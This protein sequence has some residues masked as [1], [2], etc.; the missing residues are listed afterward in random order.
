MPR[1]II[2]AVDIIEQRRHT[3]RVGHAADFDLRMLQGERRQ[4]F[5]QQV[6]PH[7]IGHAQAQRPAQLLLPLAEG[8]RG[9]FQRRQ[10]RLSAFMQQLAVRRQPHRT[11]ATFEQSLLELT[12]QLRDVAADVGSRHRQRSRRP[13]E[14]PCSTTATK[15]RNRFKSNLARMIIPNLITNYA[16]STI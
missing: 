2:T 13:D 6:W 11:G 5:A 1:L 4:R 15:M 9:V 7:F 16:I 12:L 8:L 10:Q 14:A 3:R